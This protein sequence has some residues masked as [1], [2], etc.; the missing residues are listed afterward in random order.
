M[1]EKN[2][3]PIKCKESLSLFEVVSEGGDEL[4]I[5]EENFIEELINRNEDGLY[6]IIENYGWIIKSIISK[7]LFYLKDHQDECFN[8]CLYA[9]WQNIESFDKERSSFGNWLGGI[10]RYKSI[11]YLRKHLRAR[12]EKYIDDLDIKVE[13]DSIDRLLKEELDKE[14]NHMLSY[15]S[16]KDRILFKRFYLKEETVREISEDT[17]IKEGTL[18]SRL[19]RGK[20]KI[21][22]NLEG[23]NRDG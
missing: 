17:N 21:R 15:L 10:A 23:G 2:K 16:E 19:S 1:L 11:D 4:I 20:E 12:D 18:Y 8:D 3:K 7:H 22:E 6:F 9:V 13:D 14:I 5:E